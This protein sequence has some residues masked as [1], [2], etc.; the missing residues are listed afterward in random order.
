DLHGARHS[1]PPGNTE[2]YAQFTSI[3][4]V[5]QWRGR[6]RG[7]SGPRDSYNGC[8]KN[9][10]HTRMAAALIPRGAG[11]AL[12]N[13]ATGPPLGARAAGGG[14]AALPSYI[15]QGG[16]PFVG[17]G[18]GAGGGGGGRRGG[19]DRGDGRRRCRCR[20]RGGDGPRGRGGRRGRG[21]GGWSGGG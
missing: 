4:R 9:G 14:G 6:V 15:A 18:G 10:G 13:A 19:G 3:D 5:L 21:R 20:R 8:N 12:D 11:A 16:L 2:T 7:E 17:P 1:H